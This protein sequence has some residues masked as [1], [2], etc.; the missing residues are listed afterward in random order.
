MTEEVCFYLKASLTGHLSLARGE[1]ENLS[2]Q[3]EGEETQSQENKVQFLVV[4]KLSKSIL[5]EEVLY[6]Y[7]ADSLFW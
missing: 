5:Y 6:I 2:K 7:E 3:H 1:R 4:R